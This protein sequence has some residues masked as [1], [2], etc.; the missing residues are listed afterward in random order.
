MVILVVRKI[1]PSGGDKEALA[2]KVSM[3]YFLVFPAV[4]LL[5]V[6]SHN[7]F[8]I[9]QLQIIPGGGYVV[10][11]SFWVFMLP[12]IFFTLG[13]GGLII[14]RFIGKKL[15]IKEMGKEKGGEY[16]LW[17][18]KRNIELIRSTLPFLDPFACLFDDPDTYLKVAT[19]AL[20]VLGI[21]AFIPTALNVDYYT[22]VAEEGIYVNDWLSLGEEKFYYWSDVEGVSQEKGFIMT[23]GEYNRYKI[24]SYSVKLK[25]RILSL[26]DNYLAIDHPMS[27][28]ADY[29][30]EK[31]GKE[32]GCRIEDVR[33]KEFIDCSEEEDIMEEYSVGY[34]GYVG[35]TENR[36]LLIR[37]L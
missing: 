8:R 22:R 28:V 7:L 4:L 14:E 21:I 1:F 24:P 5:V 12:I 3:M 27:E 35:Q 2:K 15:F 18:V 30:S 23:T 36:T 33:V 19:T 9:I 31:S 16:H 32:I 13:I 25:D 29:I 10:V 20:L 26:N 6:F 37:I 34:R 17:Y 11:E